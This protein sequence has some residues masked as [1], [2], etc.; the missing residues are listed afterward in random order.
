MDGSIW[1]AGQGEIRPVERRG[2]RAREI[3]RKQ[4]KS[5]CPHEVVTF[6]GAESR[7][8]EEQAGDEDGTGEGRSGEEKNGEIPEAAGRELFLFPWPSVALE[9]ELPLASGM[10]EWGVREALIRAC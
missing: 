4:K 6:G 10:G 9:L 5:E 7:R 1:D 2:G 8:C 3:E